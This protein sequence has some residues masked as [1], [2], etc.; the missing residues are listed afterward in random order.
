MKKRNKPSFW[1]TYEDPIGYT[2]LGLIVAFIVYANF[3]KDSKKLSKI[4]VNDEVLI[5]QINE[6]N[7]GFKVKANNLFEV[8]TLKDVS[9]IFN[10]QLTSKQN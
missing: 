4:S 9:N 2:V 5:T 7:A 1:K 3:T 8:D 10:N 6:E